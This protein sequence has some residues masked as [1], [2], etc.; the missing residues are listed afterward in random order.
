MYYWRK[1]NMNISVFQFTV[2]SGHTADSTPSSRLSIE[3]QTLCLARGSPAR[4]YV[5][6]IDWLIGPLG[7]PLVDSALFLWGW[8]L[9]FIISCLTVLF[10]IAS[11]IYLQPNTD[12]PAMYRHLCCNQLL[13]TSGNIDFVICANKHSN[14]IWCQ[15]DPFCLL[16]FTQGTILVTAVNALCTRV[17]VLYADNLI[18]HLVPLPIGTL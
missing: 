14:V 3:Y 8:T 2:F 17:C 4:L 13:S 9:W 12:N 5:I 1:A 10:I 18:L 6:T 15:S 16:Y 7:R 11:R